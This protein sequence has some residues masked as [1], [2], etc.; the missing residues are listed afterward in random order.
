MADNIT[1]TK[2]RACGG[3]FLR[4]TDGHVL[5]RSTPQVTRSGDSHS[6]YPMFNLHENKTPDSDPL[7]GKSC[8]EQE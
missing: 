6:R 3:V 2:P 4:R 5:S 1:D 8:E 7:W